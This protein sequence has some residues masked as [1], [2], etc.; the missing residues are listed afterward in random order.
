MHAALEGFLTR[1]K[2]TSDALTDAWFVVDNE[3]TIVE[4][5]RAFFSL[6]P[7]AVA[8]GLKG[9]KCYEVLELDICKEKCIGNQCW[10]ERQHVRLNDVSGHPAQSEQALRL[11][12]V[13]LPVFDDE[14]N[15]VGL[16]EVQRNLTDETLMQSKYQEML[17]KE[18]CERERLTEQIRARTRE[19]LET[20]QLLLKLQKELLAYK[21]GLAS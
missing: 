20:N 14:G 18:A 1:F 10:R 16:L 4:F 5:N 19:I 13:G 17:E 21:K 15:P 9:K 3:R 7:R 6:L 2:S 11:A 12:L 8:R